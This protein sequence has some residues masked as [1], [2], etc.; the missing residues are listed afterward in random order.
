M[1][2]TT[3]LITALH[4]ALGK[5]HKGYPLILAFYLKGSLALKVCDS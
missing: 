3:E 5:G 4:E 2:E 1:N